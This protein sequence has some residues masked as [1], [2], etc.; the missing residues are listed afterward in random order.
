MFSRPVDAW[1]TVAAGALGVAAGAGL[2]LV[3]VLSVFTKPIVADLGFD[4][5]VISF[6]HTCFQVAA[7]FGTVSLGVL[8]NRWG[9]RWPSI[10]Y[11]IVSSA[12]VASIPLLPPIPWV[13]FVVFTVF[14]FAGAAATALPYA[15]AITGLF[16]DRRGLALGLAVAGGGVGATFGPQ[17]ANYL[18]RV[19]TWREGLWIVSVIMALPIVTMTLLVRTPPRVAPAAEARAAASAASHWSLYLATKSFWLIAVTILGISVGTFGTLSIL[20]PLLTDRGVAPG[21]A[22][23]ILSSAGLSS[24]FARIAIGWVLDRVWGP[25][26]TSLVCVSACVGV[27]I[28]AFGGSSILLVAVGASLMGMTLGAEADLLTYLCS[29]Y[30]SLEVFSRVIGAMWVMWAWGGGVGIA[31]GGIAY[32]F[33]G[34]YDS[35]ML[36]L[37]G[38]LVIAAILVLLLGP[39]VFA[40]AHENRSRGSAEFEEREG[41]Q[42]AKA[43][44]CS[45]DAAA[46]HEI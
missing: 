6:S 32:K 5:S 39:Y 40:P 34:A 33:T 24:F 41:A 46:A 14:G 15:V 10:L 13:F 31:L 44:A 43:L 18:L 17:L 2:V 3:Y 37:A 36:F 26:V 23:S 16:D 11:L 29:R 28:I 38:P 27:L 19:L 45:P 35:A 1:W 25:L 12:C 30:F 4:R 21:D 20:V 22:A 7:G 8:I 42:Q 9:V